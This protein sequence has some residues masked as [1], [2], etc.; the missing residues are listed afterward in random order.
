MLAGSEVSNPSRSKRPYLIRA[1]HEWMGDNGHTPHIVV[2]TAFDGVQVPE[3]HIK[4]GKIKRAIIIES[5]SHFSQRFFT[6]GCF[7]ES[8]AP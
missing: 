6:A 5:L 2:D 4:D 8:A 1:M 3:A 7:I